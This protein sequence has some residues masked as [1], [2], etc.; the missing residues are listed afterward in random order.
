MKIKPL[1]FFCFSIFLGLLIIAAPAHFAHAQ[2]VFSSG[3]SD[4]SSGGGPAGDNFNGGDPGGEHY[5]AGELTPHSKI[6]PLPGYTNCGPWYNS[7]QNFVEAMMKHYAGWCQVRNGNQVWCHARKAGNCNPDA[8]GGQPDSPILDTGVRYTPNC[9]SVCDRRV[10]EGIPFQPAPINHARIAPKPPC[11]MPPL[12]Q[13]AQPLQDGDVAV[14]YALPSD[15]GDIGGDVAVAQALSPDS[16][17][18]GGDVAV[19]LALP[20]QVTL[21]GQATQVTL[22]GQATI[23]GVFLAPPPDLVVQGRRVQSGLQSSKPIKLQGYVTKSLRIPVTY[24]SAHP[25]TRNVSPAVK[26]KETLILQGNA[27]TYDAEVGKQRFIAGFIEGMQAELKHL[28]HHGHEAK[29]EDEKKAAEDR[30]RK[31]G[32]Q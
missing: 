25:K 19:A 32:K 14:A 5:D 9:Q 22:S 15:N 24:K 23:N 27:G 17:D 18:I 7:Y 11:S 12:E 28:N 3:D 1:G 21:N 31:T 29:D 30:E 6:R 26:Q 20:A 16:G 4:S 8:T 13:L 10:V 2:D